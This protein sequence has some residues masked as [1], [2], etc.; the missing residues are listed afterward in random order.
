MISAEPKFELVQLKSGPWSIRSQAHGET[1]H[2][3]TGPRAEALE[4]HIEQQRLVDRARSSAEPFIIWDVGLGAAGNAISAIEALQ[5]GG[6]VRAP[7][8]IHSFEIDTSILEFALEHAR[9][10]DYLTGWEPAVRELLATGSASPSPRLLWKLHRGDFHALLQAAPPPA[11]I[12]HDPYSPALNPGMF[13]LELFKSL[14]E[15]ASAACAL[16]N[17]T[18]STA[19]RVT[20]LLAG[21]RVGTGVATGEKTETTIASTA[22]ETLAR[23]LTPEWLKR[24]RASTNS[25]PIRNGIY[26]P[27]PIS[28]AD[29]EALLAL[30]QFARSV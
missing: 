1:M 29:F 11:S 15:R 19:V 13:S 10:L 6:G 7:V 28:E 8:E 23:P 24:V 12:I 27:K 20:L 25:A 21:W 17:Y 4:L 22:S 9:K 14:R 2:I 3:G 16:T 30:P 26:A 18:R 5:N